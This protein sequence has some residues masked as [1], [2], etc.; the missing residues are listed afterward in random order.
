MHCL[1]GPSANG[2][3]GAVPVGRSCCHFVDCI[4]WGRLPTGHLWTLPL[5][6]VT[7]EQE[8]FP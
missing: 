2:P 4:L 6:E 3:Y 1:A 7:S 8:A 5:G